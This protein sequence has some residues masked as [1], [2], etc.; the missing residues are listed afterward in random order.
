[1][2]NELSTPECHLIAQALS[3][4]PEDITNHH[5]VISS[6]EVGD[7]VA[8]EG[9][10]DDAAYVIL[11][12]ALRTVK[13]DAHQNLVTLAR[14]ERGALVGEWA[15]FHPAYRRDVR[16]VAAKQCLLAVIPGILLRQSASGIQ[17]NS[18]LTAIDRH[19]ALRQ[20]ESLSVT[21][22]EIAS[23]L[24]NAKEIFTHELA[25]GEI[26]ISEGDPA[27][28]ACL[29]LSGRLEALKWEQGVARVLG[30]NGPGTFV[31]EL[32]VL[33]DA[34]RAATVRALQQ[35][36]VLVLPAALTRSICEA[37]GVG[38]LTSA[39]RAGYAL[40]GRGIA[41]SVLLPNDE[42]DRVVTTIRQADGRIITVARALISKMV[43]ARDEK[44]AETMLVSPD[45]LCR[46]GILGGVPVLVEGPEGWHDL[47][48]MMDRLLSAQRLEAWRQAA[49]EA[50]GT[51]LFAPNEDL[52]SDA[53]A[54]AC[55]GVT[56]S[57]IRSHAGAGATTLEAIE[58]VCG[59]GGVCGGCRNRLTTLLGREN[60]TLCRTTVSSLS[61][62]AIRV[63][64]QAIGG[65]LPPVLPGQFV[66]IDI[67]IDGSWVSRSYTVVD[68]NE[69][70][71]E[72]GVKIEPQGLFSKWL[73]F[74]GNGVF[75]R[76]SPP[77][78][79]P[80]ISDGGPFLFM[81]AGIGVTPAVAALRSQVYRRPVHVA[82]VYR[83]RNGAAYLDELEAAHAAGRITL[84]SWETA[85]GGRPDIAMFT[86]AAVAESGA[87]EALVCGPPSWA[88]ETTSILRAKGLNV[89]TEIFV[90]AGLVVGPPMVCP[91]AWREKSKPPKQ[92]SWKQFTITEPGT[93]EAE[94][95]SYLEQFFTEN[96][97]LGGFEM[98]WR[99]VEDEIIR[100][101]TYRQTTE[102]LTFGARLAWRNATRCIGRL[103]WSGL[104]VRD[105]R[106]LTHPDDM[107]EAIFEHIE[108]AHN[109]GNLAP[110]MTVFNPGTTDRPAVRIWNPQLMRYAA[111]QKASGQ[112]TGDPAQIALTA[113][114]EAL[115]WEGKGSDFDLLPIVIE[116]A[117][118]KAR[119]YE[120]PTAQR[121]EVQ[122][123]HPQYPGIADLGLKWYTVPAV[124][125][126]ALDCGGIQYRC[127]PFSG[128]YMATE[129]GARNFTDVE[130]YNLSL[131]IAQKIG[132]DTRRER[133]LWRDKALT[134]MTEAVLWSFEAE[135]VKIADHFSASMEFLQ[136]CRNEQDAE[137][138]VRGHWSWLVPPIGGSATPLF[139][140]QW[141]DGEVKPSFMLQE[142]AYA[143]SANTN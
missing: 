51:L 52:S 13:P 108:I 139:L 61:D 116:I 138:E 110:T 17:L 18:D 28:F 82:Y 90:H 114:I 77:Q 6:Y 126:M 98:R 122:I 25:P 86:V 65:D 3:V 44:E 136:F 89:R 85:A 101:G 129:I 84:K 120:I 131:R 54:C 12:G 100:T 104:K 16:I 128:W 41:Y 92:P 97:A 78:G 10:I 31:G 19:Q 15:C 69:N 39:L 118:Q 81:A 42:E 130:R 4:R 11:T 140:D 115:G 72:F 73:A 80:I 132:A 75:T 27:D 50:N 121:H 68:S 111:Y 35:S 46:I 112:I 70:E 9:A 36:K 88:M 135:G 107:A 58:R 56:V 105:L 87:T 137:R 113:K 103:Y 29:I 45:G 57:A 66:S 143:V 23:L 76:A 2:S 94:A 8:A 127:A 30:S 33:E 47:P 71:M 63:K 40:S 67:L 99:E 106:H 141:I 14:H 22:A 93:L 64:L 123:R 96:G 21:G 55:T 134:A 34:P 24:E 49:F 5:F 95:R 117:D 32:G 62:G 37:A 83:N 124:S 60:F 74:H 91:G 48:Q 102:E 109:N 119:Y 1:V 133:T 43:L 59:A 125:D 7:T 53:V 20:L 79:E 142:P 38:A 26:L